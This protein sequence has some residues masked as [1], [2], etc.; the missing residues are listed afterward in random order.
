MCKFEPSH[1]DKSGDAI[2][3]IPRK[4]TANLEL[5]IRRVVLKQRCGHNVPTPYKKE[6]C[7]K[8]FE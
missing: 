1:K 7:T 8:Q 3:M 4:F 5:L 2:R 6:D